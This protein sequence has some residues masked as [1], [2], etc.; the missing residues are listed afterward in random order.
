MNRYVGA[1]LPEAILKSITAFKNA[2][3]EMIDSMLKCYFQ[4]LR[5]ANINHI[6]RINVVWSFTFTKVLQD[7]LC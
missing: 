4:I 5:S 3:D 7:T 1:D 6:M 2:E